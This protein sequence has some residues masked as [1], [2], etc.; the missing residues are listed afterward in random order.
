MDDASAT[1]I[2]ALILK[3]K[4]IIQDKDKDLETLCN[5]L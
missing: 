5:E 3:A 4:E 2:R 1:N